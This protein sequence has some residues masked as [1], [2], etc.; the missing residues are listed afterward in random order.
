MTG[1][2]PVQAKTAIAN[3]NDDRRTGAPVLHDQQATPCCQTE[4]AEPL[5]FRIARGSNAHQ[6]ERR[7]LGDFG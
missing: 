3:E 6:A 5:N 2:L 4:L 7:S 1:D